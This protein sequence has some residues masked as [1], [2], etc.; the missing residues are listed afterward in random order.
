MINLT[1]PQFLQSTL[2]SIRFCF[3][4]FFFSEVFCLYCHHVPR[5]MSHSSGHSS[6]NSDWWLV[7]LA[8]LLT[9]SS[10]LLWTDCIRTV[11][12]RIS[13]D[14]LV[15]F[16]YLICIIVLQIC[17]VKNLHMHF[18]SWACSLQNVQGKKGKKKKTCEEQKEDKNAIKE[19]EHSL[20]L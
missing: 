10:C 12:W 1:L 20:N 18:T 2:D 4:F 15:C 14:F 13:L 6:S 3:F 7:L 8:Y 17:S 9:S 19:T 16:V 11:L 5:V